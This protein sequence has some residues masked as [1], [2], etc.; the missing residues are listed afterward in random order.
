MFDYPDDLS[1]EPVKPS[2]TRKT[3]RL[4]DAAAAMYSMSPA[5]FVAWLVEAKLAEMANELAAL[6]VDDPASRV[7]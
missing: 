7:A 1:K 4:L 3:K 5:T 2:F 6:D